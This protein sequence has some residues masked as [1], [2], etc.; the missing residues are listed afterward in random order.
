[1]KKCAI[2]LAVLVTCGVARAA[3]VVTHPYRG[4][5]V[6]QRTETSP[7]AVRM[8]VVLI[9]LTA[10]GVRFEVEAERATAE[11]GRDTV[12]RTAVEAISRKH[13]QLAIN[14][15]FFVPFPS[16]DATANVVGLAAS[17]GEIISAFEPQPVPGEA[18]QPDQS[19]AIVPFA[20]ALNI[21]AGNHAVIVHRDATCEDNKH[22]V[23]TVTL[24]NALSG[25][26]QIIAEGVKTV[27]TYKDAGHRDGL[28][29]ANANY[30]N[31]R[32]WYSLPDARSVVGLTGDGKTL[33]LFTVD[34]AAGSEGMTPGEIA[35]LLIADY[36][37]FNA[38]NLDGGGSTS[39]AM[40]DPVTHEGRLL[41]VSSDSTGGRSVGCSLL[42]FA[43]PV[44][45]ANGTDR[46]VCPPGQGW[47]T[48][49]PHRNA[50]GTRS[51]PATMGCGDSSSR[52]STSRPKP[53]AGLGYRRGRGL[54]RPAQRIAD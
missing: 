31:E 23:E 45:P 12:R 24:Y 21:D 9:D 11:S 17:N 16:N 8:N 10:S 36:G 49:A 25:S 30:S 48:K 43:E 51:V 27:P 2:L 54:G 41:N 47:H 20:P 3:T 37:V 34:R 19:Y 15:N 32:S 14:G 40:A 46:N 52:Y 28:L 7:R 22:V 53:G 44:L 42:V 29:N 33:V 5:T 6:T 35:E 18:G 4:V 13:A 38:L 26:A 1:M 50:D 39:L